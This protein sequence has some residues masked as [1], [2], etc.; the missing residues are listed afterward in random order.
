MMVILTINNTGEYNSINY[1]MYYYC[2][3]LSIIVSITCVIF[4]H[5]NS[6]FHDYSL[7]CHY[8]KQNIKKCHFMFF[9]FEMCCLTAT[10]VHKT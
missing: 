8:H 5:L 3:L 1:F 4:M 6:L 2:Y 10:N 7:I 9:R